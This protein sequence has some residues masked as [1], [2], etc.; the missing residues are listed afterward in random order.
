MKVPLSLLYNEIVRQCLISDRVDALTLLWKASLHF[1]I[2]AH[3]R[4][5]F[6]FLLLLVFF[7]LSKNHWCNALHGQNKN[8]TVD[9]GRALGTLNLEPVP[10]VVNTSVPL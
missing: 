1:E 10:Y 9:I 8:K 4:H 3:H 7:S 5:C 6:L 2:K